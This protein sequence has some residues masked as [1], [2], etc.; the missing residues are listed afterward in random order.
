VYVQVLNT[1]V[2]DSSLFIVTVQVPAPEHAPDH[3]L[4]LEPGAGVAVRATEVPCEK[5]YEQVEPQLMPDGALV[6]VPL[7]DL[8]TVRVWGEGL[9]VMT[10][11]VP[12]PTRE[13]P[14]LMYMYPLSPQLAPQL[15]R[16]ELRWI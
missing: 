8:E 14:Y 3:P 15:L 16:N 2:T 4:K 13:I 9:S 10:H 11:D 6:T 7:P 1:A 12:S 5:A